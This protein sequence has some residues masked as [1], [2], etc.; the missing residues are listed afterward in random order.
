[1][2]EETK[3]IFKLKETIDRLKEKSP[4]DELEKF[5]KRLWT[6][7]KYVIG[8]G[9]KKIGIQVLV[10]GTIRTF[11]NI[12]FMPGTDLKS[13]YREIIYR[14]SEKN[15][16]PLLLVEAGLI[17]YDNPDFLDDSQGN[18]QPLFFFMIRNGLYTNE[19]ILGIAKFLKKKNDGHISFLL[20]KKV[21]EL[22]LD[23]D[24]LF[25]L[26]K[27]G[28]KPELIDKI[29][30]TVLKK[31]LFETKDDTLK[32]E[33]YAYIIKNKITEASLYIEFYDEIKKFSYEKIRERLLNF[34]LSVIYND[35]LDEDMISEDTCDIIPDLNFTYHIHTDNNDF[36][37]V[38]VT[39]CHEKITYTYE[40]KNG[41][42]DILLFTD[43][44]EIWFKDG[45]G[46]LFYNECEIK[47][48]LNRDE[49][50]LGCYKKGSLNSH[51]ILYLFDRNKNYNYKPEIYSDLLKKTALLTTVCDELKNKC[52]FLLSLYYYDNY[53]A[54]ELDG[55]ILKTDI[56]L[57]KKEDRINLI[58]LMAKRHMNEPVLLYIKNYGYDDIPEEVLTAISVFEIENKDFSAKKEDVVFMSHA[59]YKKGSRNIKLLDFLCAN[60]YGTCFEMADIWKKSHTVVKDTVTLAENI[61]AQV[62]FTESY[63]KDIFDIFAD[64]YGKTSE[65]LTVRAFL[66]YMSYNYFVSDEE[67]TEDFFK[68]LKSDPSAE[69]SDIMTL[70]LLKF[71]SEMRVLDSETAIFCEKLIQK[72]I[73]EKKRF[74]FFKNFEGK[75]KLPVDIQNRYFVEYRCDPQK[76]VCIHY[77]IND[78]NI[79]TSEKMSDSGYGFFVKPFILFHGDVLKYYITENDTCGDSENGEITESCRIEYRYEPKNKKQITKFDEINNLILASLKKNREEAYL[80]AKKICMND[81]AAEH[82]F[83]GI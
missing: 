14:I 48:Y 74:A 58:R 82:D 47:K 11:L 38:I 72:F 66:S 31:I 5:E 77:V 36:R 15:P 53:S 19:F 60:Y 32:A 22:S 30:V 75:I 12:T 9:Q 67:V 18:M 79:V 17:L 81:F 34:D 45:D 28:R 29:D 49:L 33:I 41:N 64:F 23:P 10:S 44:S 83:R 54:D 42:A 73:R 55:Y 13:L 7:E 56:G 51:L 1:M 20:L 35:I 40:L 69:N 21:Y 78:S 62:M 71:Y 63:I 61:L 26:F 52:L 37:E 25:M 50:L 27:F 16:S 43:D 39:D 80:T 3:I 76:E 57:L 24:I 8:Y 68:I 59:A 70:A 4:S 65:R 46:N 6:F 2:S